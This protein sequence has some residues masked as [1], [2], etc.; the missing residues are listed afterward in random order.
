MQ[1]TTHSSLQS[2]DW[3]SRHHNGGTSGVSGVAGVLRLPAGRRVIRLP[4]GVAA[5]QK[6][7]NFKSMEIELLDLKHIEERQNLV[8]EKDGKGKGSS[9]MSGRTGHLRWARGVDRQAGH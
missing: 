7:P 6:N 3:D 9:L 5:A 1:F 8:C 4:H 2:R